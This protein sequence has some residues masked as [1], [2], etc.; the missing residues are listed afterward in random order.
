MHAGVTIDTAKDRERLAGQL[1]RVTRLMCDGRW[2]TLAEIAQSVNGSEAG[3]SARLRDL[4]KRRFGGHAVER[5]RI[6]GGNGL[7]EYRVLP[8]DRYPNT[9]S[10]ESVSVGQAELFAP[11]SHMPERAR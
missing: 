3:V 10:R 1:E 6:Y 7:H 4:R 5:R 8:R 2:R 9:T 11:P